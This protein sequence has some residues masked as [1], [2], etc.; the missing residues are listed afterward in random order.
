MK[1]IGAT[2]I[3]VFIAVVQFSSFDECVEHAHANDLYDNWKEQCVRFEYEPASFA[4]LTSTRP[5]VK[6]E[7]SQ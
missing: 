1:T 6:P 4:P 2:M 5:P 3:K 7:V